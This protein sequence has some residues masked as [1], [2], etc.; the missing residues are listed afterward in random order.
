MAM[1]KSAKKVTL[2]EV[3]M[4]I[5]IV[6]IVVILIFPTIADTKKKKRINEEVFPTFKLIQEKNEE[7]YKEYGEYAFD[8]SQLNI[9]EL[10]DKRYF[11]FGVTDSTLEATTTRKFGKPGA[12]IIYNFLTNTWTVEGTKD[13]IDA[14][15]LP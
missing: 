15:W 11:D 10:K 13:V 8:I 6:G 2:I 3:L 5:L 7:F 4:V 9:A 1:D 12:K 14:H